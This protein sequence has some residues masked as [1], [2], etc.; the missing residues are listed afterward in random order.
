[1]LNEEVVDMNLL[2][3]FIGIM[4]IFASLCAIFIAYKNY[5]KI[6][7][8]YCLCKRS[9]ALIEL[10]DC[11]VRSR[12]SLERKNNGGDPCNVKESIPYVD[13]IEDMSC[14]LERE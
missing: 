9:G 11:Y 12:S 6:K 2:I 4:V 13:Y 1:M 3:L 5:V 14:F 7:E 10:C 8:H